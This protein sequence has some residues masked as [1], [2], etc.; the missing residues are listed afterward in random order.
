MFYKRLF[1]LKEDTQSI[2]DLEVAHRYLYSLGNTLTFHAKVLQRVFI[3]FGNLYTLL[4]VYKI[5]EKLKLV[6][7]HYEASIMKPPSHSRPQPPSVVPTRS[8]HSF[9]SA[10]VV[11]SAAPILP[12]CNYY[13]NFAHK[14]NEYNIPSKDFFCDYCGKEGH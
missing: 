9:S 8:S 4:D 5:S 10:K 7:A 12:S 13:D 14:I 3:E 2:I 1:K 6:H 11:Q